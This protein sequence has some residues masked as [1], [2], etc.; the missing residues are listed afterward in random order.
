MTFHAVPDRFGGAG[1]TGTIK[2]GGDGGNGGGV[3]GG[4]GGVLSILFGRL[5]Q[6]G[7]GGKWVW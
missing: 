4:G 3:G 5:I 7:R 1:R 2:G 6:A